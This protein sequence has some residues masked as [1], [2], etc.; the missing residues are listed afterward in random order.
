MRFKSCVPGDH[1]RVR[2]RLE[3]LGS[4]GTELVQIDG[5]LT[6]REAAYLARE[7]ARAGYHHSELV[8]DDDEGDVDDEIRT[9]SSADPEMSDPVAQCVSARLAKIAGT[10]P[11]LAEALQVVRYSPGQQYKA[12]WDTD[13]KNK[14]GR[15]K[16][17]FAILEERGLTKGRCGGATSFPNLV[18]KDGKKPLRVYPKVGRAL[19]WENVRP[20]GSRDN[21]TLHSGEKVTCPGAHK[22]GLNSWAEE[23]R[24]LRHKKRKRFRSTSAGRRRSRTHPRVRR[25]DTP[26]RSRG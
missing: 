6:K 5:L 4:D 2:P 8:H 1:S 3:R 22:V 15:A 24:S 11:S 20:H 13:R 14:L 19:M 25:K 10:R 18:A 21:N 9:S 16:T 23:D 12:H 26:V 17:V 7:G